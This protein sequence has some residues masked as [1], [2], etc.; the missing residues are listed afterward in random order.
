MST[1]C[2]NLVSI[3]MPAYNAALYIE[4]AIVSV[5]NQDYKEWEL[6]VIDDGSVDATAEIIGKY[7]AINDRIKLI[8]QVNRGPAIAR[9]VG[10]NIATGN[11]LAFLDSD[12]VWLPRKISL[13]IAFMKKEDA[14]F[15]FTEFRRMSFDKKRVGKLIKVPESISYSELLSNTAI[16]TS[17]VVLDRNKIGPIKITNVYYD[18]YVLWLDLLRSKK[19]LARGLK[20]DLMRYRIVTGSLSRNKLKSAFM[21]WQIYR[22]NEGLNL[23]QSI[24][25]FANYVFHAS[26]KYRKF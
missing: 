6:I 8:T 4:D 7:A 3:I 12:D 5:I 11:F 10:V 17:T 9:Q 15:S 13:Q 1:Y 20:Q 18:D 22:K 14:F 19:F 23:V 16:A 25:N 2:S 21:V 24:W 26:L